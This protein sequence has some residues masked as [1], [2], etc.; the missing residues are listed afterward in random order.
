MIGSVAWACD[1]RQGNKERDAERR[2][3][4]RQRRRMLGIIALP[5]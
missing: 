2:V 1:G 4:L 3:I 5:L